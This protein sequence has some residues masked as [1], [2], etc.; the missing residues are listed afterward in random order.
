MRVLWNDMLVHVHHSGDS[1]YF[2]KA[3][4]C[5]PGGTHLPPFY[6]TRRSR[7]SSRRYGDL[8]MVFLSRPVKR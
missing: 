5:K 7:T 2:F 4:A 6:I 1:M 8:T 3:A